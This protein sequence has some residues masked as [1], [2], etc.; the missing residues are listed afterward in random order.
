MKL[1]VKDRLTLLAI[2]PPTGNVMTLRIVRDLQSSLSFSEAELE[3][4]KFKHD[5]DSGETQ[6]SVKGAETLRFVDVPIGK[7]AKAVIQRGFGAANEAQKLT[8]S[9]LPTYEK[10]EEKES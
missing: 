3:V 4:L 2:L 1:E 10:F 8:M 9:M 5:E 7:E 6:W